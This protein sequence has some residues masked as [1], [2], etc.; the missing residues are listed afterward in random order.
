MKPK[1][2]L[3]QLLL[4]SDSWVVV[5]LLA[6]S[7][8][9]NAY[10][11]WLLSGPGRAEMA[12]GPRPDIIVGSILSPIAAETVDKKEVLIEWTS[13]TKPTILYIF[14]PDCTWCTRNL[15]NIK[16][17]AAAV[18]GDYRVIWLS[19]S[20]S[21]LESYSKKHSF[22]LPVYVNPRYTGKPAVEFRATPQTLIIGNG[23]KVLEVWQGAYNAAIKKQ[24]ESKLTITLPGLS[25][26]A[27]GGN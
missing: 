12:Q 21:N 17:L 1:L 27:M 19:L 9:F 24:I 13:T 5:A 14:S 4:Y 20:R 3:R 26:D 11:G 8:S 25:T 7:L 10:Q 2:F 16:H 6:V 15:E 23:G 22:M 18:Q